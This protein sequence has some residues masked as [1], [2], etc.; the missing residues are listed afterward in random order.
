M[1]PM[2]PAA[3]AAAET[4]ARFRRDFKTVVLGTAGADGEPAASVAA[5]VLGE[6][7]CFYAYVSGLAVHTRHLAA[8]PRASVLLLEDETE[9][10]QPLAR[11]R[12]TFACRT[13]IVARTDPDFERRVGELRAKFGAVF[14]MLV[15]LPDFVLVRLEPHHGRLVVGFGAAF[16]VAPADWTKLTPVGRPPAAPA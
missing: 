7:L 6:D 4:V 13:R 14:D 8:N 1:T 12:L 15:T 2:H 10:G 5:A 11:R 9:A 3:A 16:E